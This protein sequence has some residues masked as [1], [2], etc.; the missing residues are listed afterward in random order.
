MLV[1]YEQYSPEVCIHQPFDDSKFVSL[2]GSFPRQLLH[3]QNDNKAR[4][5]N[6]DY[7]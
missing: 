3:N 6:M 7:Y 1:L 5:Q 2:L 4:L